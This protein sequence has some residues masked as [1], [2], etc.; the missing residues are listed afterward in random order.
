MSCLFSLRDVFVRYGKAEVLRSISL[1]LRTSEFVAVAGPNGAGK[2]TLLSVLAGLITPGGGSCRFLDRELAR[3]ARRDF[4][5]RVAVVQQTEPSDFPFTADEV[6]FMGRMPHRSGMYETAAD[7]D[8]VTR[9]LESTETLHLRQ[10]E[11]R[12]LSGGEKQR[13]LLASALAQQPEVLLLDEPAS[14]LDLQHQ[15]SLHEL[16]RSLSHS[17]LLIVAIT[18]DLNLAASYADRVVLLDQGRIRANGPACEVV[19]VE[20][21]QEVFQ[22]EVQLHRTISGRPWMQ[23]GS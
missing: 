22:V 16:L 17:G 9:A 14:H 4:T 5:R 12:T 8:A 13:V 15:I 1:D 19:R 7:R 10:R 2:S 20:L 6:V 21:I 11:Y 23:Y 18:H 3:W